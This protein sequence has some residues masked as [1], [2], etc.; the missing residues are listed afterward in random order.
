[1]HKRHGTGSQLHF[2]CDY[3]AD[4][5][6]LVSSNVPLKSKG[7]PGFVSV[8]CKKHQP[9]CNGSCLVVFALNR[10]V[11]AWRKLDLGNG[12][13]AKGKGGVDDLGRFIS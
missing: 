1:M 10:E 6:C 13:V 12:C 7:Y 3:L 5:T 11:V 8:L 4:P 9:D 2:P